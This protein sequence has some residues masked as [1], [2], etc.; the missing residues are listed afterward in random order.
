M[1]EVVSSVASS[2][3]PVVEKE[4][5]LDVPVALSSQ[6][7]DDPEDVSSPP[8]AAAATMRTGHGVV[9]SNHDDHDFAHYNFWERRSIHM[10][11]HPKVY[12]WSALFVSGVLGILAMTLPAGRNNL[13]G[14][15]DHTGWNARGTVIGNRHSQLL[16]VRKHQDELFAASSSSSSA[17][18]GNGVIESYEEEYGQDTSIW[19]DLI[20]NVA[21]GWETDN[22][23]TGGA[24]EY[25]RRRLVLQEEEDPQNHNGEDGALK[26]SR[27]TSNPLY[28]PDVLSRLLQEVPTNA[29]ENNSVAIASSTDRNISLSQK[30]AQCDLTFYSEGRI[31]NGTRLW[32]VWT[33]KQRDQS[34]LNHNILQELCISEENTQRYLEQHRL[35]TGCEQAFS[36][37]NTDSSDYYCL[38]PLSLVFFARLTVPKG[39]DM[40]CP[41]LAQAW[42]AGSYESKLASKFQQ[43]T[44]DLKSTT[45]SLSQLMEEGLPDTCPFG[46][47]PSLADS[48][49]DQT[50][51]VQFTSSIF[52]TPNDEDTVQDL[53]ERVPHFDKGGTYIQG[54]YGTQYQNFV[55]ILADDAVSTDMILAMASAFITTVAILVHTK[56]PFLT[57]AGLLQIGLSFPLS[58]FIYIFMIGLTFF[59]FLNFI[60][61][62]VVFAL[63]A[64]D[65]FVA[66]DKWKNYR[67][68]NHHRALTTEQ[69]AAKAL[70]DAAYAMLLT[71]STTAVAFFG[72]AIC[73]VAPVKVFAI[74][75]G[76]LILLDYFMVI[77]ILFPCL[78]IYDGYR[79]PH[80]Q[81]P[82]EDQDHEHNA[83]TFSSFILCCISLEA[84]VTPDAGLPSEQQDK[85]GDSP[86]VIGHVTAAMEES[87]ETI[88]RLDSAGSGNEA[89]KDVDDQNETTQVIS[90]DPPPQSRVEE[91]LNGD[92]PSKESIPVETSVLNSTC[93]DSECLPSDMEEEAANT[94]SPNSLIHRILTAYYEIIYKLRWPLFAVCS[95][96]F[97][98]SVYYAS[99]LEVP[100]NFEVRVLKPSIEF[101]HNYAWRLHLLSTTL[102]RKGGAKVH[103]IWG[104]QPADTGDHSNPGSFTQLVL[105]ETF[106]PS[107]EEAQLYMRDFCP[108]LFSQEFAEKPDPSYQ[109]PFNRFDVWL[110]SMANE[111]S[112]MVSSSSDNNNQTTVTTDG[113]IWSTHCNS[114]TGIPIDPDF[115]HGC[116]SAWAHQEEVTSILSYKGK[117]QIMLVPFTSRTRFE[118]STISEMEQEWNLINEWMHQVQSSQA[119]KQVSKAFFTAPDFW[120]YDTCSQM[121]KTAYGS[122][123]IA[124]SA[125]AVVIFV[126]SKS[127]VMT[128][129]SVISVV[130]VLSVVISLTMA[131]GWTL[132]FME[133][134]CFA[135]AIGISVDFVIHFSHAY[136][137]PRGN[138]SREERTRFSLI[139]MGPSILAAAFTTIAG[140]TIMFVST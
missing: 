10:A 36:S 29:R 97:V 131:L 96:A 31:F 53:Y 24:Q 68:D 107:S 105:D 83:S 78:C 32:P 120:Y 9:S 22:S 70:P 65:I 6:G 23:V 118:R 122:M 58:Y 11:Q 64:D 27:K 45:K 54:A 81:S 25:R 87:D 37:N 82:A 56:S 67:K 20:A 138:V 50:T 80:Q 129:Y 90:S 52:A 112:Y 73:T 63:G 98:A 26:M 94:T 14:G 59:P 2:P 44:V 100:D 115:F 41:Q 13:A 108:A 15:A 17:S 85:A 40:T 79:Y 42:K 76:L 116:I 104:V 99:Q 124:L 126:S 19:D 125:S 61:V 137:T 109:C 4:Q 12:F 121:Y 48:D 91:N 135:I 134:I 86:S 136:T 7:R 113:S 77:V 88:S 95:A 18:N 74:F 46:F 89:D 71:T 34:F 127:L 35:C 57:M 30:L 139:H 123:A 60:G 21:P 114:A 103:V 117:V 5:P 93:N 84:I 39:M 111:S 106:D 3:I 28:R 51:A 140:A 49:V 102:A 1:E 133:S 92:G 43:C 130:F 62:F 69:V 132:G 110:Q 47:D 8:P 75:C 128:L 16:L 33:V 72:T 38:P 55:G 119:P 101:E 66:V